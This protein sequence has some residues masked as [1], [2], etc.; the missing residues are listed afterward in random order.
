MLLIHF[1]IIDKMSSWAGWN[2]L[3][4]RIRPVGLSWRPWSRL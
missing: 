2:V 3:V 1:L 4:G